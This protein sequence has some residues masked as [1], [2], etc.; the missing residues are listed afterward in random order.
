MET[1][2]NM[3]TL[4]RMVSACDVVQRRIVFKIALGLTVNK[5]LSQV[6]PSVRPRRNTK[7]KKLSA[8]TGEVDFDDDSRQ[9]RAGVD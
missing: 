4:A 6:H 3:H 5:P 2:A 7:K 8:K 1:T 9:V